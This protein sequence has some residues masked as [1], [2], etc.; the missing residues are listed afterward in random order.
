MREVLTGSDKLSALL[1]EKQS[2]SRPRSLQGRV[3]KHLST[4]LCSEIWRSTTPTSRHK[5]CSGD[6][7]EGGQANTDTAKLASSRMV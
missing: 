5:D 7:K 4:F 3:F 6:E 2:L 1:Q